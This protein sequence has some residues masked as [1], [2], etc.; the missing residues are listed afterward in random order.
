MAVIVLG[1]A[2]GASHNP[3]FESQI[4][5]FEGG[6]FADHGKLNAGTEI[7]AFTGMQAVG[8]SGLGIRQITP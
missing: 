5:M 3:A 2:I 1:T 7:V 8:A 4:E 6:A